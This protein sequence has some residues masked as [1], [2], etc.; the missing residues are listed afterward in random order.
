MKKYYRLVV[1]GI[2]VL[3]GMMVLSMGVL[4]SEVGEGQ[5]AAQP[6]L[7]QENQSD[8]TEAEP[9]ACLE[10][11]QVEPTPSTTAAPD[12]SQETQAAGNMNSGIFYK[13]HVQNDGWQDSVCNG[14][15]SGTSGRALRLE[16]IQIR[17]S[18]AE[19]S[20]GIEYRTH[21]Q[22]IGWE[23]NFKSNG[24]MS[25]TQGKALRLEAIQIQLTG[26]MAEHYDVYYRVHCQNIG[27]MGWAQNGES[28]G[29]SGYAYRLE[30]IQ[31]VLVKKGDAAP[32]STDNHFKQAL[33]S[34]QTHVEN[35]GWMD[36]VTDG[37]ES[38]TDG[39]GL[40]LEGIRIHLG[41]SEYSGGIEY[42]THIQNIG[43]ESG[44][45]ADG[46]MSGTSGQALRLEAIQ[47]RLT[48][49]IAEHYDVYYRVHCQNIGWMGWASNGASAGTQDMAYRLE[50]IQIVLVPKGGDAPGSTDKSFLDFTGMRA[51]YRNI[52]V[53]AQNDG[54][55]GRNS[56]IMKVYAMTDIDQDGFPELIVGH[57]TC[58]ANR[59]FEIFTFY[60]RKVQS[61]GSINGSN[62][63]FY[64]END[65][66]LHSIVSVHYSFSGGGYKVVR[67]TIVDHQLQSNIFI[68]EDYHNWFT[69]YQ[70]NYPIALRSEY[71][72][73]PLY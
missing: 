8:N 45:K 50:A 70:T 73:S 13:T 19:Y 39:K 16:A 64:G 6:T 56:W 58:Q 66:S 14:Q 51:T 17:L 5:S 32:G 57:G 69:R 53:A 3:T 37:E 48:G 35:Y 46:E 60:D 11:E 2:L 28:A 38:G 42:R 71:D 25:G 65:R 7:T 26:D 15:T 31:I 62:A 27:W 44:F 18:N 59:K 49:D 68:E 30:A 52:L 43:W 24:S 21:I 33:V 36:N 9:S 54:P 34:Y 47:I 1:L 4:A 20:G 63:E 55:N 23:S 29:S 40:R 41:D 22:N 12:I 10:N 67:H 72:L 61:L